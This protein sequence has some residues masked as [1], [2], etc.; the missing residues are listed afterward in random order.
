MSEIDRAMKKHADNILHALEGVS[1][2]ISQLESRT[3]HLENSVDDLKISAGNNHGSTDG[4]LRQL[5]NILREVF[6]PLPFSEFLLVHL[7]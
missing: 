2:R 1:A 6:I 5:E 7:I 4:Q 3:R